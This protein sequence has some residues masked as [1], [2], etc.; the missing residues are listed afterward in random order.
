MH[1]AFR[2]HC[3]YCWH[4]EVCLLTDMVT[5]WGYCTKK[6]GDKAPPLQEIEILKREVE[7][8]NYQALLERAPELGLFIPV[9][10]DCQSFEE[11]QF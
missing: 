8:G 9:Y 1:V 10:T 5:E 6:L 2:P 7:S 3:S 4:F 11:Y